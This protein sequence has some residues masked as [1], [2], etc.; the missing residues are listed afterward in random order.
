MFYMKKLVFGILITQ[1]NKLSQKKPLAGICIFLPQFTT[2]G[3]KTTENHNLVT[4]LYGAQSLIYFIT[5]PPPAYKIVKIVEIS[6]EQARV[7]FQ[8]EMMV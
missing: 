4:H 7:H 5:V 6:P 1:M 2:L 8:L 3:F